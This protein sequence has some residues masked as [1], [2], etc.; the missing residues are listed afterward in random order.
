M[1]VLPLFPQYCGATTGAV[2]DAGERGA[3]RLARGCRRCTSSPTTTMTPATSRRCARSVTEHWQRARPH[4]APADVVSR[5][6]GAQRARRAIRTSSQC[7]STARLLA[8]ELLLRE[9]EWSVSFQSRFGPAGWLKP[10][11]SAVLAGMPARGVR[12]VSVVCPGF[13]V[14]CLET[15]EEIDIENRAAFLRA[16]GERFEYVPALNARASHAQCLSDLIAQHCQGWMT[17]GHEQPAAGGARHLRLMTRRAAAAARD[18]FTSSA[19]PSTDVPRGGGVLRATRLHAGHDHRYLHASL[20]RAHRRAALHRPAP[21]QRAPPRRSPSCA[22]AS[23][24]ACPHSRAA[25]HR[26]HAL[27]HRRGGLQRDRASATRTARRWRCSRR[28]PTR[29]SPAPRPSRR[30]AGTSPK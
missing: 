25:G 11:T 10:Y 20:R 30:C 8:D 21:A 17:A 29:R 5:H 16:G 6:S 13:A 1:L 28:A 18:A 26:A 22:P 9:G 14:D 15:L 4:R 7:Q 2:F 3:A 19:S 27:S 23:P 12:E 24:R